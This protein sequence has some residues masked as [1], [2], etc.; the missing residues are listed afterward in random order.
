MSI[1]PGENVTMTI[2]VGSNMGRVPRRAKIL[3]RLLLPVVII[4]LP[5]VLLLSSLRTFRELDEQKALYLRNRVAMLAGRLE[6]LS[7]S[8]TGT[9]A[10][11][12]L[13]EDEPRLLDLVLI[14]RGRTGDQ[15]LL[16]PIWNGREL[17]RTGFV[18]EGEKS[19]YRAYVPFHSSAGLRIARIDLDGKTADFLVAHASHNVIIASLAAAVLVMLSLYG[20]WANRRA[21]QFEVRQLELEHLAHLGKMAAVLAHE[22]RNPLGTIKGFAQLAGERT[23]ASIR[24]LLEPI[25]KETGRLEG[26]VNDLLLYGR[27]PAPVVRM[28]RWEETLGPLRAHAQQIIGARDI[29]FV[30]DNPGLEWETDPHLLQEALLNLIRNAADAIGD[31]AGGEVRLEI[32]SR[33]PKGLTLSVIDN[34]PGLS[35]AASARLFEP[36]FTTKAFGTGLGLAITRRLVQSLGGELSMNP[37]RPNGNEAV[38]RFPGIAAKEDVSA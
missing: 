6:N 17:F 12:Q 11:E 28:A 33:R 31:A 7:A 13:S 16:Q 32:R 20:I 26:L 30:P 34:G 14:E 38:L 29:R 10:F 1:P 19:V 4:A 36:F 5:L 18:N 27:P 25:L 37:A 24:P 8:E 21:A 9:A 22:I 3:S 15:P 35:E 23:D 2:P